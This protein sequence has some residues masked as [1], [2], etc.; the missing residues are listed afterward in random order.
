MGL[1]TTFLT[2]LAVSFAAFRM[3]RRSRE[4]RR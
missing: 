3:W 2:S 1:L 4:G